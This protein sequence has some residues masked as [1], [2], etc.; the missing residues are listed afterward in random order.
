M[1]QKKT[2][3]IIAAAGVFLLVVIG[4]GMIFFKPA[5][6]Y[7]KKDNLRRP[8]ED[9]YI[10]STVETPSVTN[11][12]SS[13][14]EGFDG[15]QSVNDLVIVSNNT[16]FYDMTPSDGKT[17]DLKALRSENI[18]SNTEEPVITNTETQPVITTEERTEAVAKVSAAEAEKKEKAA[19]VKQ[20]SPSVTKA[21]IKPKTAATSTA[22]A[23]PKVQA[24]KKE[25]QKAVTPAKAITRYWVQVASYTNKKTAENARS[26]LD[27]NKILADIFTFED[28]NSRLFYRV[29]VGPYTTKS[30][31]E[32]WMAKINQIKDFSKAGSYVTST[33]N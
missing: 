33:K 14:N 6:T 11:K 4:F 27:S 3:W 26:T 8:A 9:T 19:S 17:I 24:S 20:T 30:E 12:T 21:D 5:D 32:Y 22:K 13:V 18:V 7:A 23:E 29:R 28:A 2:L 25:T 16:S 1:E 10:A 15:T 31:A